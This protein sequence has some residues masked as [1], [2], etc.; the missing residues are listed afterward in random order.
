MDRL[1]N[2][3]WTLGKEMLNFPSSQQWHASERRLLLPK[4]TLFREFYG[5]A[6]GVPLAFSSPADLRWISQN[7]T[8]LGRSRRLFACMLFV[9]QSTS[10]FHTV[11]I[12]P[13]R[14]AHTASTALLK[15]PPF[16]DEKTWFPKQH[17]ALM[18][19]QNLFF[20]FCFYT[21]GKETID[22]TSYPNF[23]KSPVVN[24]WAPSLQKLQIYKQLITSAQSTILIR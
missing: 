14:F 22:N 17:G 9:R 19:G 20:Y 5:Q 21:S 1:S 24:S 10:S 7:S 4:T 18:F 8:V 2:S 12:A 15:C 6:S 23:L 3:H 13:I 16:H 11:V